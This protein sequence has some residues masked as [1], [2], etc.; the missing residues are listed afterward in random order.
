MICLNQV[1]HNTGGQQSFSFLGLVMIFTF[2]G[3]LIVVGM[4]IDPLFS[5][6][7]SEDHYGFVQWALEEKLQLQG[8]AYEGSGV[9][10]VREKRL[11]SVP[12]T[13]GDRTLTPPSSDVFLN[14]Y[15]TVASQP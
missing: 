12:I 7:F 11:D 4:P 13:A 10:G 9:R 14:D 1:V 2:S 6:I 5:F 8:A 15:T 3:I